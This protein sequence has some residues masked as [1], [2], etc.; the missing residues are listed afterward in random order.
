MKRV[1]KP[2]SRAKRRHMA[3]FIFRPFAASAVPGLRT[4]GSLPS[5]EALGFDM[6]ALRACRKERT[7]R[8]SQTG[9]KR[10]TQI[11]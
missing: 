1:P 7:P 8:P 4:W 2:A 10:G 6:S 5:A 9:L 3:V 11:S